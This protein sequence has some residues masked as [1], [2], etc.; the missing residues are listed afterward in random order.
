MCL[1]LHGML[2]HA[3]ASA[4]R[5]RLRPPH[6]GATVSRRATATSA[7]TFLLIGPSFLSIIL[8]ACGGGQRA[9]EARRAAQRPHQSCNTP[10]AVWHSARR[11]EVCCTWHSSA[12]CP[13]G[14]VVRARRCGVRDD[15]AA[16]S[17]SSAQSSPSPTNRRYL[18]C[19]S[20]HWQSPGLQTP[21][22]QHLMCS[23][24]HENTRFQP[25]SSML[26]GGR[27]GCMRQFASLRRAAHSHAL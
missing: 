23:F 11:D 9:A 25:L 26:Q 24:T 2:G 27:G 15:P 13:E 14:P 10:L 21:P 17:S 19:Q 20:S 6:R 16:Q 4:R 12:A 5:A 22:S 18:S 8:A 3:A 7:A 1:F